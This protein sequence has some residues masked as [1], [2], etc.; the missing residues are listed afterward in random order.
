MTV[1]IW[2]IR[3][4]LRLTD[5]PALVTA[6]KNADQV[7]PLFILD[8]TLLDKAPSIKLNFLYAGLA[9]FDETLRS[10]GSRLVVKR[11]IPK[12]VFADL[13]QE[14][15][16]S[17][18]FAEEDFTTYAQRRDLEIARNFPLTLVNGQ[19]V[20]SPLALTKSDGN[21]YLVFTPFSKNWR[22]RLPDKLFPLTPP[23]LLPF[24]DLSISSETLP[25]YC[26]NPH[27]LPGETNAQKRLQ[28]FLEMSIFE[29]STLRN[30]MD[31]PATSELSPYFH[32]GMLSAQQ[33]VAGIQ[34]LQR[35]NFSSLQKTSCESWI[36]ELIWREFYISL[37]GNLPN[38]VRDGIHPEFKKIIW[39]LDTNLLDAW[40]YGRTGIPVVDAGMRQ[41]LQTGW[42]HN[43]AR[44]ITASFLV[45]NCLV[46][47]HE[48]ERW[49]MQHLIDGDVAANNGGWQW[50][51]GVG[52]DAAPYFRVFNPVLQSQKFDPKG[53]F[54][55]KWVP[56]LSNLPAEHIHTPWKAPL[57]VQTHYQCIIGKDYP[58]PIVDLASSRIEAINTYREAIQRYFSEHGRFAENDSRERNIRV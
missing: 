33:A 11:G 42:M 28:S 54:I 15:S 9:D 37:Q 51:A 31:L 8:P 20:H 3:R 40:K 47:W 58:S 7:L 12:K 53:K 52:A 45:K 35:N 1:A 22:G 34:D 48:G 41:L 24:P 25:E 39:K 56:E 17:S 13:W 26:M 16:F 50:I 2:W 6:L 27:F 49:F 4:D 21:P 38:L 43:R 19:T 36:N 18:I 57:S 10:H 46:D 44:M 14:Y 32:F 29:Y 55:R 5:N 23:P 30:R